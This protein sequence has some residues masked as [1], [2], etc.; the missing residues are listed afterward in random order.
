MDL[1][2]PCLLVVVMVVG[3]RDLLSV[4]HHE[5]FYGQKRRK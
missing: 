2:I 1:V 5:S 4:T 3:R